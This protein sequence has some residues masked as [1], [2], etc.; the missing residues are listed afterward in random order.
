M[1]RNW[2][3]VA[4]AD[5]V[6]L[7]LAGGFMQAGHGKAAPLRRL[8]PGDR[9]ACYSPTSR[10]GEHEK[11]QAFTAIGMVKDRDCYQI[12]MKP[13]FSP[14]RRDVAWAAAQAAPIQPL[15]DRLEF[16][17]GTRNWG[18]RLRTGLFTVS[19]HD[20]AAIG[21]AMSAERLRTGATI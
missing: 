2:I 16:T 5:H 12:T 8:Q 17:A 19:D 9:V 10:F 7:G 14:Y 21:S 6:R 18:Y 3:V 1:S 11:L 20:M 15:L 13:G 4:A